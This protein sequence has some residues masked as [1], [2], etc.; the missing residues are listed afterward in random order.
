MEVICGCSRND[1]KSCF[2]CWKWGR[3]ELNEAGAAA[4]LVI[5]Q[6]QHSSSRYMWFDCLRKKLFIGGAFSFRSWIFEFKYLKYLLE[7][8]YIR[9]IQKLN[10]NKNQQDFS[11][12]MLFSV[13]FLHWHGCLSFPSSPLRSSLSSPSTVTPFPLFFIALIW[14]NITSAHLHFCFPHSLG[15]CAP[16]L[17]RVTARFRFQQN[18]IQKKKKVCLYCFVLHL[19]I[20]I[21]PTAEICFLVI[22][23]QPWP[24]HQPRLHTHAHTSPSAQPKWVNPSSLKP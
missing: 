3:W 13:S 10:C 1:Q 9:I 16:V 5:N 17:F 18:N 19:S 7:L 21:V 20:L 12:L 2:W 23:S 14:F 24:H 15:S 11:L 6:C 4:K 22:S 8:L